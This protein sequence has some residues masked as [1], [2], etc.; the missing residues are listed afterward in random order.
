M[1]EKYKKSSNDTISVPNRFDP[2][3]AS[4]LVGPDLGKKQVIII[5]K[6]YNHTLQTNPRHREEE[7]QYTDC[8]KTSRRQL[9]LNNQLSLHHQD[10]CKTR[11]TQSIE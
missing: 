4:R 2:G 3:Q 8:Q 7:P 9:K 1:S 11:I 10:D 6:Y 5:R